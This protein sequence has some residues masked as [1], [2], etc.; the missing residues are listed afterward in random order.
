MYRRFLASL[1]CCS[2]TACAAAPDAGSPLGQPPAL[3]DYAFAEGEAALSPEE[4]RAD[5]DQLYQGLQAAHY[6]LYARQSEEAYDRLYSELREA[7]NVP[8]KPSEALFVFQRF[9]A[10]GHIAHARVEGTGEVYGRYR[11]GGGKALSIYP[12]IRDGRVFVTQSYTDGV[13]PGDEILAI[14]GEPMS[15]WIERLSRN[16]SADNDYLAATLLELTFPMN[17][18]TET[19]PVG[20]MTLSVRSESGDTKDIV[21]ATIDAE[22]QAA[23]IAEADDPWFTFNGYA[24]KAEMLEGGVAYLQ[25]GPF[26]GIEN[27]QNP[28]DPSAFHAFID[29][30]FETFLE[31]DAEALLIDLRQN[32]GGDNSFS[33]HMIAWFADEPFKFASS[34]AI[35]SSEQSMAS[36]QARIDLNPGSEEGISGDLARGYEATPFGETFTFDLPFARPRRGSQFEGPVFVLVDRYSFSN[37]VNVAALVQDYGFAEV[38]GEETSDLATTYGA[39]ETFT[40]DHSG[41][42][43]GYPKA[44]IVRASGDLSDRGVVPDTFIRGP[45][46][47]TSDV[48]LERTV[49]VIRQRM[50]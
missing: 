16:V 15:V 19:G 21:A 2:V 9:A 1:L 45:N 48:V 29:E 42:T 38:M 47:A 41:L 7:L 34:F 14:N 5:L 24:R 23:R 37:A 46:F 3:P 28:W 44:M 43:V 39:M 49:E 50:E 30:S 27:P 8:M 26:Y 31:A 13:A 6:D 17:L 40:L 4:L 18:L 12:R 11:D 32:P 25:P 22:T 20:S 35:R 10:F 36:N 33:D